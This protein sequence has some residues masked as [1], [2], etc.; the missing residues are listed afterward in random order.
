MQ[1]LSITTLKPC[2]ENEVRSHLRLMVGKLPQDLQLIREYHI[3]R[4]LPAFAPNYI[5]PNFQQISGELL[6]AGDYLSAPSQNG[7]LM[8]GRLAAE[9]ALS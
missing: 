9:A 4:S 8:S 7:A 6:I 2:N 5:R 3:P 1:L